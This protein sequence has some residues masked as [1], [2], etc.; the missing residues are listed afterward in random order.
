MPQVLPAALMSY[1]FLLH[2]KPKRTL[3]HFAWTVCLVQLALL[4]WQLGP[5]KC[6]DWWRQLHHH[7]DTTSSKSMN[8]TSAEKSISSAVVVSPWLRRSGATTRYLQQQ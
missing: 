7:P 4:G 6:H 1:V 5:C 8:R 2:D 3:Q